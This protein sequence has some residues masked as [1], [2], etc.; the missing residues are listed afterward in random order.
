[1]ITNNDT[2]MDAI[3]LAL[4]HVTRRRIL[5]IIQQTPGAAVGDVAKKFDVSRIAVMNHIAVLERAGL[6]T[7]T[8]TGRSRQLFLN[9]VPIQIIHERWLDQYNGFWADQILSIKAEAETKRKTP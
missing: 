8:K 4:G 6:L 2:D 9:T 3:F 7:S 1:M 5:D